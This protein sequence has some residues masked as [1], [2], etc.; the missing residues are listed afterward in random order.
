M[1]RPG[2]STRVS[3]YARLKAWR[4]PDL[5]HAAQELVAV[6]CRC[7][8]AIIGEVSQRGPA[9]RAQIPAGWPY[10]HR[11]GAAARRHPGMPPHPG[12]GPASGQ[13]QGPA[14]LLAAA[15][16]LQSPQQASRRIHCPCCSTDRDTSVSRPAK[17]SRS[18]TDIARDPRPPRRS[19]HGQRIFGIARPVTSHAADLALLGGRNWVRTSDPSLVRLLSRP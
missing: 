12:Q 4:V 1:T 11:V 2:S 8:L 14:A 18:M 6:E 9:T 17:T 10:R 3:C 5:E 19:D 16:R 15:P 13:G 7:V